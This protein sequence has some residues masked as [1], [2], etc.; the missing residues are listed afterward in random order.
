M[1]TTVLL[2]SDERLPVEIVNRFWRF[3]LSRSLM[4]LRTFFKKYWRPESSLS[5]WSFGYLILSPS[6]LQLVL[7]QRHRGCMLNCLRRVGAL[8]QNEPVVTSPEGVIL[9]GVVSLDGVKADNRYVSEGGE[10]VTR[11]WKGVVA[12]CGMASWRSSQA[13]EMTSKRSCCQRCLREKYFTYC[14]K[15]FLG[16]IVYFVDV[17]GLFLE[18][19]P[20]A[21]MV[22]KGVVW[23]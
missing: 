20:M 10:E 17:K 6:S 21:F 15:V 1:Y 19:S 12:Y 2:I 13:V 5:I 14:S 9:S 22:F 18:S 8:M 7:V 23:S 11:V 4:F 16:G 3:L